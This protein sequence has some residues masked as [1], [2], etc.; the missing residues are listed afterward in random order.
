VNVKPE[1]IAA[2]Q[3]L[4]GHET[5]M[6]RWNGLVC[7]YEFV[8]AG[9]DGIPRSQFWADFSKPKDPETGL[10]PYRALTDDTMRE[11]LAN[12]ERTFVGNPFDGTGSTRREVGR[13]YFYNKRLQESRWKARGQ[14]YADYIWDHRRHIRDA[15]AGP[16][17]TVATEL[18]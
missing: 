15:G 7:R 17:V 16:L 14:E 13:R 10:Q 2:L 5:D 3:A 8:M 6:I 12:L 18:R 9:A 4:T 1:W 11:A